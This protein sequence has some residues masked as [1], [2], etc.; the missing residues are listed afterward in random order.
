MGLL[1]AMNRNQMAPMGQMGPGP[2]GQMPPMGGPG[3]QQTDPSIEE[4][5]RRLLMANAGQAGGPMAPMGRQVGAG[6]GGL[7]PGMMGGGY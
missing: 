5:I 4:L 7:P 6:G 3:V 2:P 1:N